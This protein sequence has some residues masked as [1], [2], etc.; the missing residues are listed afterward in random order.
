MTLSNLKAFAA[1]GVQWMR[2]FDFLR[3]RKMHY[4]LTFDSPHGV[5]VLKD[6]ARFCRAAETEFHPDPR[7]HAVLSGRREVFLRIIKHT[8]LTPE[9][10]T[11]IYFGQEDSPKQDN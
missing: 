9:A 2:A 8:T 6:L 4:C 1:K 7:V 11:D 5:A 10:L 3:R